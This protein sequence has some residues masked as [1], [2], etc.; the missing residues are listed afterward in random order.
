MPASTTS[1]GSACESCLNASY[2]T[3]G[4]HARELILLAIDEAGWLSLVGL[5]NRGFLNGADRGRPRVDWHDLETYSEGVIALTGMPGANGILSSAI[6]HSAN[7]AEPIEAYGLVHRLMEL[8]PDR[9]YLEL[10]FHG[11][12][13]EKL[14]NRGL[15]AIAQRMDLPMVATGGVRFA[16]PADALAHKLLEAIGRGATAE[17]V[18]GHAGRDGYDLPTITVEA[19]RAQAYLKS[20]QQMWRAFGQMPAALDAS[21]EI[22]ERCGFRLPLARSSPSGSSQRRL[23]P[24]L[25]FGLAPARQVSEQQLGDLVEEAL[26]LRFAE[27]GRGTADGR[28]SGAGAR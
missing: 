8:Y 26:P 22:A 3:W 19:A 4:E 12:P 5:N 14:V 15:V 11:N 16:R 6:E 17:G 9:L 24:E 10:A 21:V 28:G 7:P 1:S 25:L 20:P 27:T 2:R 18:L 23:G 13:A